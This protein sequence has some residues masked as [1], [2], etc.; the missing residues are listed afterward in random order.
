[1]IQAL[2]LSQRIEVLMVGPQA[3]E[4]ALQ[5]HQHLASLF[6]EALPQRVLDP[7]VATRLASHHGTN[8]AVSA[9]CARTFPNASAAVRSERRYRL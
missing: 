7:A 3:V 9:A 1:M 4:V 6:L 8:R 2:E 5:L